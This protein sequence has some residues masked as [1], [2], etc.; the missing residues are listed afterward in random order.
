VF[1]G[2]VADVGSLKASAPLGRGRRM[3]WTTALKSSDFELGESIAVNGVCLTVD[4][5][6]KDAFATDVSPET[7][8]RST[9][10]EIRPGDRVNLERA[11]R[12]VD[13]LGGHFVLGHV[14]GVGRLAARRRE[15]EFEVLTFAAPP[16]VARYLVAKGSVAV[17]GVSLTVASLTAEG[18]TVAVIPHTLGRTTLGSAAT[19]TRVNLE[20]DILGK[21]VEKLL[22]GREASG[23][24]TL[25][26][27]ARNGFIR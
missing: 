6:E 3:I 13:R 4:A 12:P 1:T 2:I 26:A 11:L 14:D 23:G 21:Y 9:L 24:L 18:F 15:G 17:A 25:E 22:G 7:L 5:V 20:A 27:L 10:G 16:E 19:G 8:A